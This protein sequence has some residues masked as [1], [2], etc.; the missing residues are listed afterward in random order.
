MWRVKTIQPTTLTAEQLVGNARWLNGPSFLWD[1][2]FQL[3]TQQ[4]W[5]PVDGDPEV[6]KV[7]SFATGTA[8]TRCS[9]MPDRLNYFSCWYRAKRVIAKFTNVKN[10][11]KC[12]IIDR[13]SSNIQAKNS[14]EVNV[15]DLQ[16]TE[17]EMI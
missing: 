3:P 12:R 2:D 7:K 17:S 15:E 16:K 13:N 10:R 8:E 9:S 1:S 14:V 11:L 5:T 4:K 6:K